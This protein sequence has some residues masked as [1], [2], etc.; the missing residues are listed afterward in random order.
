[1]LASTTVSAVM[2]T[3]RRT[4][5]DGVRMCTGF[6]TPSR[7]GP[8]VTPAA[9]GDLE[10][11]ERDVRGIDRR[12]DQQVRLALEPRVGKRA[13]PHFLVQRGVAVHLAF[14]LELGIHRVDERERRLHLLRLRVLAAAEA[15]VRQQRDLRA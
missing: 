14:D 10:Q 6:A 1:M 12:H 13:H 7:I 3:I 9:R 2:L 15:R 4:V 8:S 11:V 5:A